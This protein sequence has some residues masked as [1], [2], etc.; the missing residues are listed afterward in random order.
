MSESYPNGRERESGKL[1]TRLRASTQLSLDA[2]AKPRPS[3]LR[4]RTGE[5]HLGF[6]CGHV[7]EADR[8]GTSVDLERVCECLRL[9]GVVP[10]AAEPICR[11]DVEARGKIELERARL[12]IV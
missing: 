2:F 11:R 10:R 1:L 8:T 7:D 12:T 6:S 5:V 9:F 3:I 4:E